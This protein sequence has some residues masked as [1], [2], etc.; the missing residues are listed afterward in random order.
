[1]KRILMVAALAACMGNAAAADLRAEIAAADAR[2]FNALNQRDLAT[3]KQMFSPQLEFYHDR[4]GVTGYADN[5]RIFE[6]KFKQPGTLRREAMP[7]TWHI[8]PAGPDAAMHIGAHRFCSKDGPD[9]PEGCG[10]YGFSTV[11]ARQD[12]QW[13]MLRVLSY[14]H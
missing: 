1:M 13:K 9:Q 12:G 7:E 3:M 8:Y 6:A 14:G 4:T 5:V 10:V 2:F 11:W